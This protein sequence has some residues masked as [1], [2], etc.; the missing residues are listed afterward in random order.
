[1]DTRLD[2]S[3]TFHPQT[4]GQSEWTI[5]VLEHMFELVWLNLV[6]DG[7]NILPL[8]AFSYNKN[9]LFHYLDDSF[10]GILWHMV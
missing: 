7:I 4:Y 2:M 9:Y 1:M 8:A 6:L 5:Q 3:I 10:S